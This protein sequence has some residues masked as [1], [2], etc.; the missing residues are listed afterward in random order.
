M[1]MHM[2]M[3]MRTCTCAHAR[4][5]A[6]IHAYTHAYMH[7]YTH[8]YMHAYMH[9]H[10]SMS[11][12]V[13]PSHSPQVSPRSARDLSG[14]RWPLPVT[15]LLPPCY[16]SLASL[17]SR[18]YMTYARVRLDTLFLAAPPLAALALA[19]LHDA[20]VVPSGDE[21]GD[22]RSTNSSMG[23]SDRMMVGGAAAFRADAQVLLP[24]RTL[25]ATPTLKDT[26]WPPPS[27][28]TLLTSPHL[29][30]TLT[31]TKVWISMRDNPGGIV[32]AGYVTEVRPGSTLPLSP[33]G[34]GPVLCRGGEGGGGE[35]GGGGER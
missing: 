23:V 22:K 34:C 29:D 25:D 10:M 32:Q 35:G 1:H 8:A 15:C 9:T 28:I 4:M 33:D 24:A 30:L 21:W 19:R 5:H 13:W 18:S 26:G 3:H 31:L 12:A 16:L 17:G 27:R 20:V 2:H 6:Y 11:R 14:V 7:A